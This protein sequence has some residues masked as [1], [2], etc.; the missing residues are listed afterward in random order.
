MNN[1]KLKYNSEIIEK[2]YSKIILRKDADKETSYTAKLFSEG[3]VRIAQ[4]VGEE[5]VE[6]ALAAVTQNDE[7]LLNESADLIYML[8]VL[9]AA[10][11]LKP[12]QVFS[13][14]EKRFNNKE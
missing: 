11:N 10:R 6:T 7:E 3:I 14:L 5:G 13:I 2:L 8:I 4:K 12:E 9:L 1:S